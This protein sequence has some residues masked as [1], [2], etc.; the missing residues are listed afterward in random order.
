MVGPGIKAALLPGWPAR[1]DAPVLASAFTGRKVDELDFDSTD[2]I[3]GGM[4]A[5]DYFDDGSFYLLD[6]PG[7]AVGNL[8]A[9]VR[10]SAAPD[11]FMLLAGDDALHGSQLRPSPHLPLPESIS[12]PGFSPDPCPARLFEA[13]HAD[14]C[15]TQPLMQINPGKS[16][17]T[18]NVADAND[19]LRK[20]QDFDADDRVF[21]MIAHDYTLLDVVDFFPREANGWKAKGWKEEGRWRFLGDFQ[22]A[23]E[24][25]LERERRLGVGMNSKSG[26]GSR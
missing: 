15:A 24:I 4:R 20:V 22:R 14:A 10:T 25:V 21:V 7:H 17:M 5:I 13:L 6:A 8:N 9:L 12:L 3:V 23:V 1:P 19:T 2:L 16:S 26:K 11:T 18:Y